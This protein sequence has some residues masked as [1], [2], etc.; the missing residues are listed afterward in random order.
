MEQVIPEKAIRGILDGAN[1]VGRL[2][3]DTNDLKRDGK[4]SEI[5]DL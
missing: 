2:L 3:A 4:V 1:E 5:K